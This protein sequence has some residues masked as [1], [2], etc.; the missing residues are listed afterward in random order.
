MPNTCCVTNT[1]LCAGSCGASEKVFPL[2]LVSRKSISSAP[3]ILTFHLSAVG[4]TIPCACVCVSVCV[5]VHCPP[6]AA[7]HFAAVWPRWLIEHSV[8][9]PPFRWGRSQSAR[10]ALGSR[11]PRRHHS[12]VLDESGFRGLKGLFPRSWR[13]DGEPCYQ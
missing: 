3:Y 9:S 8:M 1:F 10:P 4:V 7:E 5:C 11:R 6:S 2:P 12:P 13:R